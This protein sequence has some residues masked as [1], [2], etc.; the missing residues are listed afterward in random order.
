ML[1]KA[2]NYPLEYDED[3]PKL[4]QEQLSEFRPVN[5]SSMEERTQAMKQGTILEAALV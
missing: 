4:T 5:F 1:E 3:S 2:E